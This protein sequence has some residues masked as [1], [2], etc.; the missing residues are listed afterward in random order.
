M[1]IFGTALLAAC[2]L[3]GI[4][5]GELLGIAIGVKANVGGVGIAMLFLIASQHYLQK[6]GHMVPAT[7]RGITFWASM[8]IPVVVAM[9]AT[10]N[11][12]AAAKAGKVALIAAAITVGLCASSVAVINRVIARQRGGEVWQGDAPTDKE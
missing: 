10:Q 2:Y 11:V 9:A 4:Y 3:L 1:A 7:E 6:K 5:T 8:Y 12:V